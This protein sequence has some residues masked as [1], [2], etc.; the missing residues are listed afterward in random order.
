MD[1]DV[2][3]AAY[4]TCL[5]DIA[6]LR[7][8]GGTMDALYM[9]IGGAAGA[10]AKAV[11]STDQ[12]T[13]SPGMWR[14]SKESVRDVLIGAVMGFL[15]TLYPVIELPATASVAQQAVLVGVV[16]YLGADF[17]PNILG[18]FKKRVAP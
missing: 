16:G 10:L 5:V 8:Q 18:Q 3:L 1:L 14:P 9:A 11:F 17:L 12:P 13:L 7:A 6:R 15:W 2:L 4:N